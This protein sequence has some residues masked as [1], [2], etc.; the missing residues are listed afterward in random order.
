MLEANL[1]ILRRCMGFEAQWVIEAFKYWSSSFSGCLKRIASKE[2]RICNTV[3]S[4]GNEVTY[5]LT[6]ALSDHMSAK[7]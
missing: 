6:L 4:N 5:Q 3:P 2:G 1:L 7:P